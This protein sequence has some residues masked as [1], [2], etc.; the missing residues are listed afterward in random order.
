LN[1]LR[2]AIF[3]ISNYQELALQVFRYQYQHN[4]LYKEYVDLLGVNPQLVN[5]LEAIPFLPI[6]FFKS[7]T[8]ICGDA[9]PAQWFESSGTTGMTNSRHY[10]ADLQLYRQ[11]F[12]QGFHKFYGD[13][14][15][16]CIIG[17][18]PSYLERQHS[19]LV[20][21]VDE[22]I[23]RS[24]A[25]ESGF[26]LYEREK[27]KHSLQDLESRQQKTLLI[28]VTFA[29]LDF[30][31]EYPLPLQ[32]T[33]LME[34]GGMKGRREEMTRAEVHT[35]LTNAFQVPAIHSE[36]GMTELL[37]Q[38][39]SDGQGIFKPADTM[40]ILLRD[41]DDPMEVRAA[42]ETPHRGIINVIDLANL[43]S[44]AFIA[45]EDA[46]VLYPDGS[47]EVTGRVDHSDIRG[48]SLMVV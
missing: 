44:C 26:Y 30:A 25:Q 33:I 29:L 10:V 2:T 15:G 45:T 8:V 31:E 4:R 21:M 42:G 47:F 48:C 17:L 5:R 11:S 20:M 14:A 28:G 34:T 23:K 16:Y 22:L 41:D 24:H 9:L 1:N 37:S 40:R 3:N 39:Y 12:L 13:P 46:G 36:Y 19:S 6:R 7:H 18:L 35:V 43:D 38:G 27:L 32:H